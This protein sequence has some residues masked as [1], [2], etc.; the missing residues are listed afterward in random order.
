M[1]GQAS[2]FVSFSAQQLQRRLSA[3]FLFA[4]IG[5][6]I[7][8]GPAATS[9]SPKQPRLWPASPLILRRTF[10]RID[11]SSLWAGLLVRDDHRTVV[12]VDISVF[13]FILTL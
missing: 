1:I 2:H 4:P 12:D 8:D 7:G 9:F 6:H 5:Q 10:A 11:E 13:I 3:L